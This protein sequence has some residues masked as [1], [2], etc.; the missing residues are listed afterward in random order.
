LIGYGC[1]DCQWYRAGQF[2]PAAH[3]AAL[4]LA[5][6]RNGAGGSVDEPVGTL[7]T[8]DRYA[9][10]GNSTGRAVHVPVARHP[11]NRRRNG[12]HKNYKD[13]GGS[14]IGHLITPIVTSL[15]AWPAAD[16]SRCLFCLLPRTASV[17]PV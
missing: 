3:A 9:L 12:F 4:L 15:D 11:R 5:Y 13:C 7:T 17:F 1:A 14:R 8:R 16:H 10:I 2:H 6:Y